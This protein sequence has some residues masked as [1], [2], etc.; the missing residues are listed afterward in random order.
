MLDHRIMILR[1]LMLF[2]LLILGS[3]LSQL[4]LVDGD[5][6]RYG[7]AVEVLTTR[8]Q[9]VSP[10]RGEILARDGKTLLA[11]SVPIFSLAVVPGA[12]PPL[13]TAQRRRVLS[14]L[15]QLCELSATL[16]LSSTK[17]L[18]LQPTLQAELAQ[19]VQ[20]PRSL[21]ELAE[22]QPLP[23]LAEGQPLSLPLT[24]AP[25]KNM[26][27]LA[28]AQAHPDLFIFQP[29][30]EEII[31]RSGLQ[32][33]RKLLLKEGISPAL[34][35]VVRENMAYLPGVEVVEGYR[36]SYPQ[37][38]S[39]PSL[40][41]LLGYLGRIN[42]CE[43]VTENPAT[44][45][46]TA[47]AD[48][49][50][51]VK[52]CGL[53]KK[54]I[55]S[56]AI[57]VLPYQN[58]DRIGKDGLESSYETELRGKVGIETRFV[59]ALE[60][61]VS[62]PHTMQPV[63]VGH[64]LL[65][66]LDLA[67]QKQVETIIQTWLNESE[68]RRQVLGGHRTKYAPITNGVAVVLD[69]RNGEVLAMVSKPAYDN[70]IW[71]DPTRM[72]ELLNFL[73]PADPKKQAEMALLSPLTNR[74]IA[75]S[76]PPGSTLKQFVGSIAL[77]EGV[78]KPET[79]L[80]DPGR[81][82]LQETG[83]RTFILPNSTPQDNGLLTV[84][85]ALKISSNVFFA[86]IAGGNDQATNLGG[87]GASIRGL[88]IGRL[89]AGLQWFGLGKPTGIKLPGE[90]AGRVPDPSWKI[91]NL[92]EPWSTGDTYNT[93]IG[94]GY[95]EVTPLQLAG[96]TA[97]VA[98]GG[99][100][101]TPQLVKQITDKSGA[102]VQDLQPLSQRQVPVDPKYL[103]VIRDG[104]RRSVTLGHN[105]GARDNCSGLSIAGKTGTA[106]FGPTLINAYGLP[107][108]QS[109]SW[110]AAFAPYEKPQVAVV[111]LL[112]GTGDLSDGS[113]TLAVPAATQILQA[114]FKAPQLGLCPVP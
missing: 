12:L 97:A 59:D 50:S 84:A 5:A 101:Y 88:M 80:R 85:D 14:Q 17:A 33:Y 47:L 105:V 28:L 18:R 89:A 21:P 26:A 35:L 30:V 76:Y 57:G 74:A 108:R 62:V 48:L 2:F 90:G 40:S 16:T 79:L 60:R 81:I 36:R 22:G 29:P 45:W 112:E 87:S 49:V 23:E 39:L 66:T 19:L 9:L 98:N 68:R 71:V 4:Q 110:F 58:N 1:A 10:Q 77:Q 113:A 46:V 55:A 69:V 65:L 83:G 37:S 41:H 11:E 27:A 92:R 61:P 111:V 24:I 53:L 54:R 44:S 32:G 7:G 99:T 73:A 95:L 31:R 86:S 100:L 6:R 91:R 3:R 104:M 103:A 38:A 20:L 56:S 63:Q 13:K 82:T 8:Y 15:S 42:E 107:T 52:P 102:V 70:N 78:I 75:G 72:N 114:Y 51:H 94:Q 25:N 43:L 34:A 109:H 64:N 106:E 96:A 67:F 93:A